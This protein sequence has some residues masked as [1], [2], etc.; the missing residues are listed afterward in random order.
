MEKTSM[1]K[2]L[3]RESVVIPIIQ[4][5]YA[6]GRDNEADVR[7]R[8]L[9]E[10]RHALDTE[11]HLTLD[12]VYGTEKNNIMNPLDGQQRLTT[13][14]LVHWY[15]AFKTG[16]LNGAKDILKRFSYETRISSREFCNRLCG[17]DCTVPEGVSLKDFI[18]GR[19]WFFSEWKQDPTIKAMITMLCSRDD[20]IDGMFSSSQEVLQRYWESL[21]GEV[22]DCPITFYEI[23]IGSDR[24]KLSDDLYIKMNA[25]GK[26]LTDFENFKADFIDW[27]YK[28]ESFSW[29]KEDKIKFASLID[30]SWTD[31]FWNNRSDDGS[32]DEIFFAFLNRYFFNSGIIHNIANSLYGEES[33]DTKLSY[34]SGFD[35]YGSI[36]EG[37]ISIPRNL[38][39]LFATLNK[40]SLT[41]N[42]NDV[43]N[44]CLPDWFKKFAFIPAYVKDENGRITNVTQAERVVFFG[45]CR[46]LESPGEFNEQQFGRWMRIVCNLTENSTIDSVDAMTA[47]IRLIDTLS[48]SCKKENILEVLSKYN[49]LPTN[50][51]QLQ[52]EIDKAVQICCPDEDSVLPDR[53]EGWEGEWNWETAIIAAE[54]H[55]FFDGAIRFLFRDAD[56]KTDW[57]DFGTKWTN[58]QKIFDVNGLTDDY[59]EGAKANRIILSYCDRWMDQ[60][61]SYT[62]ND[63]YIFGYGKDVWRNNILL[64]SGGLYAKPIHHLLMGDEINKNLHLTDSDSFRDSAIKKLVNNDIIAKAY[65]KFNSSEDIYVRWIHDGFA[66]YPRNKVGIMISRDNRDEILNNLIDEGKIKL[67]YENC[68]INSDTPMFFGWD[69]W[70]EYEDYYFRWQPWNYIDM[71]DG[72]IRLYDTDR[73]LTIACTEIIDEKDVNKEYIIKGLDRCVDKYESY[74]NKNQ[75]NEQ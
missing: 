8:F 69:V 49:K 68:R 33:D 34:K 56:G 58:A 4:R 9:S 18:E 50:K 21:T 74:K 47:R 37:D 3:K 45:I 38:E 19:T 32:I 36:L 15:L 5:D 7:K 43:I 40:V 41:D 35:V 72:N 66:L 27:I 64:K 30:N 29:S 60:I 2:L 53:P 57:R 1:W 24:L 62:Y 22:K 52:E 63:K 10:L 28:S 44:R 54:N 20:G 13:L 31:V 65:S 42:V 75:N 55:A 48:E 23:N 51:E 6:Q 26:A 59:Q 17:L 61:Q 11:E 71:Y 39:Q 70:F 46:Y 14:W 16:N 25:R 67:C 12:F 73:E